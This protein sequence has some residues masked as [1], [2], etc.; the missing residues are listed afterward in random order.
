MTALEASNEDQLQE[1]V[2]AA[3]DLWFRPT[4][5]RYDSQ[6]GRLTIDLTFGAK[7]PG[8]LGIRYVTRGEIVAGRL[9]I[10]CVTSCRVID[11]A[12][13]NSYMVNHVV[14]EHRGEAFYITIAA[15]APLRIEMVA[16][17]IAARFCPSGCAR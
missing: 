14:S 17:E 11:D 2:G 15:N 8:R 10:E 3:H 5:V 13:L 9:A 4:D 16:S 12:R 7:Q 6:R 1:V